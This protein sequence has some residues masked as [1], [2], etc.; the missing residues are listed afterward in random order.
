MYDKTSAATPSIS[1]SRIDN[2]IEMVKSMTVRVQTSTDRIVRHAHSLGY[3]EPS[4]GTAA[5]DTP[6]PVTT[7]LRDALSELE[8]AIETNSGALNLFD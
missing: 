7:T 4:K 2:D 6:R 5:I 8:R 3:F 1:M